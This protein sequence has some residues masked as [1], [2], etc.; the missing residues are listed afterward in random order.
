MNAWLYLHFPH[1][2]LDYQL[3]LQPPE[4]GVVPRA[5]TQGHAARR[6]VVQANSAALQQGVEIGMAEVLA[7]TLVPELK[8]HDYNAKREST[9]LTQLAQVLYQDMAQIVLHPPQ[10]L[11]FEV[12]SLLRLHQ[13]FAGVV[14]R[15]Q[16][17]LQQWPL[18]YVLSSGYSPLSAKLLAASGYAVLSAEA[19]DVK[20]AINK[21]PIDY[22]GLPPAQIDKLRDVGLLTLGAVLQLPRAELGARFGRAM[23]TYVAELAGELSPPQNFYHPPDRFDQQ[24]ELNTEAHSW[25]Q[26]LFPLK[27]LLQQVESFLEI[28]Q[29]STRAL[30]IR[31]HHRSGPVTQVPIQFAHAVWQQRDLLSLSQLHLERQ[32]LKQPVL[33]LSVRVQRPEPRQAQEQAMFAAPQAQTDSLN[34]LVSRLQARLGESKVQSLHLHDDWRPEYQGGLKPWQAKPTSTMLSLQ[35]PYWLLPE[36]QPIERQQWQLQWGPERIV[37]GWWNADAVARDYY[38]ALDKWQRQGWIYQNDKGWFLH[39]WFS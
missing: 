8:L 34:A 33:A 35:R 27:R 37:S 36:A 20:A 30:L 2:L 5:V 28:H 4:Q 16:T 31:A 38:I 14:A 17:R 3:A 22:S 9:M 1:L 32:K 39:G 24:V 23:T 29:W 13:G 11:L 21:L 10:G 26:L 6:S 25:T 15:M 18:R 19:T 7:S 12:Q